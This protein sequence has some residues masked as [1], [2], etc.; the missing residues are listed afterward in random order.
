MTA[1]TP[2]PPANFITANCAFYVQC[3]GGNNN[4]RYLE[5]L[6]T[7][8]SAAVRPEGAR[9]RDITRSSTLMATERMYKHCNVRRK[10]R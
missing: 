4:G 2:R 10:V 1:T 8:L 3:T 9:T 7:K 6:L 5:E